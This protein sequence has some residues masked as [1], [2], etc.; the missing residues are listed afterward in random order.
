MSRLES[1]QPPLPTEVHKGAWA[2]FDFQ[3]DECLSLTRHLDDAA[4]TASFLW[5]TWVPPHTKLLI[6]RE[7]NG[8]QHLAKKV[9]VFLAAGHDIGKHSSAFAAKVPSLKQHMERHGA[10]FVNFNKHEAQSMPHGVVSAASFREWIANRGIPLNKNLSDEIA[11]IVGGHHGVFPPLAQVV[12]NPAL[13]RDSRS[14][15]GKDRFHY[16]DRAALTAQLSHDDYLALSQCAFSAPVQMILCGI[17]IMADWI[18]SNRELFPLTDDRDSNL[19]AELAFESLKFHEHWNPQEITDLLSLFASSFTLPDEAKPRPVQTTAMEIA[20]TADE[21]CL[22][23]IEAPTGEGKTEAALAA[24]EILASRFSLSGVTIALPTCATSD[25]MLPRMLA[26]LSRRLP[27]NSHADTVL[28]HGKAQFNEHYQSLFKPFKNGYSAIYDSETSTNV[29]FRPNSWFTGRKTSTL[30]DFT[31]GTI[32]QVL[33]AALRSKHLVLRHLGFANKVII[34]DEV[35]AADAYMT[36]YLE[37]CLTWFGALGVPVVALSATLPPQRRAGLLQAYRR[38]ALS[39][40]SI[41]YD[42]EQHASDCAMWSAESGYPL[43]SC[44]TATTSELKVLAPSGRTQNFLIEYLGFETEL[45]AHRIADEA[46]FGGCI[47]VVCSTVDR[48]QSIYKDLLTLLDDDTELVLLHSRFLGFERRRIEKGLVERLGRNS[49]KRPHK[50]VVVSTQII[51]QSMDIDFDLIFSDIAPIDLIFQ[52][53]GRLHRHERPNNERPARH[54][55]ARLIIAG[56]SEPTTDATPR[57][58][59]GSAAVYGKSI[60]LRTLSTLLTHGKHVQSPT[61]VSPLVRA[62][63]DPQH[64][65]FRTWTTDGLAADEE[66]EKIRKDQCERANDYLLPEPDSR[67]VWSKRKGGTLEAR[68]ETRGRAQV[69]DIEDSLEVILVRKNG[70]TFEVLPCSPKRAGEEIHFAHGIDDELAKTLAQ[71]TVSLPSWVLR[72]KQGNQLFDS[73]EEDV[74]TADEVAALSR[75]KWLRGQLFIPL[76]LN[77]CANVAGLTIVYRQETGLHVSKNASP[78]IG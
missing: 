21:P 76:D 33:F 78:E 48:A 58:D 60:L 31:L 45:L 32:D 15:W 37:R 57:I 16:W 1:L 7:L 75:N 30:A 9:V 73:L 11:A 26:W 69:R 56:C 67:P 8:N 12:Q 54:Q 36:V 34:L 68:E 65:F 59:N 40:K 51:E 71:S 38:G 6:A 42:D 62:T 72:G 74:F 25:A 24:A 22:L 55:S 47:G 39:S 2:K 10:S 18:S 43:I 44:V 19:R 35:H 63:Y 17:L 5:D 28:S 66:A 41:K 50:L 52:R 49:S 64:E 77:N 61:D 27:A 29:T 70:T 14:H 53:A 46:R 20:H 3:T 4:C 13:K 23:L